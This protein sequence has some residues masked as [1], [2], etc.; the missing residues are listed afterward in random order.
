MEKGE[1]G[2]REG[3]GKR[4]QSRNCAVARKR[5]LAS[6]SLSLAGRLGGVR[7]ANNDSESDA[8]TVNVKCQARERERGVPVDYFVNE[9]DQTHHRRKLEGERERGGTFLGI[10]RLVN[11]STAPLSPWLR[12]ASKT[13]VEVSNRFSFES[14]FLEVLLSR[15]FELLMCSKRYWIG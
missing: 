6:L 8:A 3:R 11:R 7:D 1:K 15:G 13:H 2:G 12:F 14:L 4:E 5:C 10:G 9:E